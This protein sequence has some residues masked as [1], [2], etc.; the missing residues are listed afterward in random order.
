MTLHHFT[1]RRHF[2]APIAL[3]TL[4]IAGGCSSTAPPA[5]NLPQ[6]PAAFKET[7][8]RL[9]NAVAAEAQPRGAWWKVFADAQLDELIDTAM[10]GNT[11]I[12]LA[13]ARLT[14][15]R[16]LIGAAEANRLPQVNANGGFNR[17]GG[18]LINAAGGSGTLWTL[19]AGAS[20]EADVFGRL[21][22][23]VNAA[24]LDAASVAT[25]R[26]LDDGTPLAADEVALR[27]RVRAGQMKFATNAYF[28]QERTAERYANARYGVFRVAPNGDLLLTGLRG[29]DLQHPL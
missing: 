23:E 3:L 20:Y 14:N 22:K 16:A 11:S 9:V 7:D 26:R 24:T 18:P 28:F 29:Q 1:P 4:L 13:A 25:Y 8:T 19:S 27:Y 10:Q 15:A 17:Q 21:A 5:P 6:T 2:A 12:Q